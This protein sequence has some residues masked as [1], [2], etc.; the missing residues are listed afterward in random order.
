MAD[1]WLNY[2]EKDLALSTVQILPAKEEYLG[3]W[4]HGI[5]EGDLKF[6]LGHARVP[7][8]LIHELV[9]QDEMIDQEAPI[10][11]VME[12][13]VQGTPVAQLLNPQSSEYDRVA[14]RLNG[15]HTL[16]MTALCLCQASPFVLTMNNSSQEVE[17][18]G[19]LPR[20]KDAVLAPNPLEACPFLS[21]TKTSR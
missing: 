18:N 13:F 4:I 20:A 19:G 1:S 2:Q 7:C 8:F 5:S 11:L 15:E 21:Q 10:R 14:L 3:V 16:Q 12:D 6:F 9:D 17:I